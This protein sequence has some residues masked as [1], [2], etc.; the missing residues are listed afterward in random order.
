MS[1]MAFGVG[2][3]SPAEASRLTGLSASSLRRWLFGYEYRRE[4]KM[5]KQ[6]PLWQ[7]EYGQDQEEPF[8]GFR[9][10]IEARMVGKLRAMGFGM[11]TIRQCLA[12]A[13]EV[14]Q[15]QHPFSSAGFKTDGKRIFLERVGSDGHQNLIDLK[16]KQHAFAKVVEKS[17]LDLDFDDEKATHWFVLSGKRT[18]VID[19]SRSFGQPI[20]AEEGVPTY[21]LVQSVKAEGSVQKVAREFEV[22]IRVVQDAVAFEAAL[23]GAKSE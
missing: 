14:A 19:P 5:F 8:L 10:L 9:D 17:F 15:D 3:Y 2:A 4:D 20:T 22:P 16:S 11:P 23:A 13:A 7:P 1:Y 12:T 21:R 18:L 6:P